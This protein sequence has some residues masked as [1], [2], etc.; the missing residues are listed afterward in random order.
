MLHTKQVHDLH[1]EHT[2]KDGHTY[3]LREQ[4]RGSSG[5]QILELGEVVNLGVYNY[6][7]WVVSS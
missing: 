3:V 4:D 2:N 7:L 6:P 1:P 5:M